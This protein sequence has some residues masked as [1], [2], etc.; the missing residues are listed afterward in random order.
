MPASTQRPTAPDSTPAQ[1][2][3]LKRPREIFRFLGTAAKPTV[4]L[5]CTEAKSLGH[6]WHAH[7]D[8][9]VVIQCT[10]FAMVNASAVEDN[11]VAMIHLII[12]VSAFARSA[13]RSPTAAARSALMTPTAAAR[14][15]FARPTEVDKSAFK[16]ATDFLTSATSAFVA[17]WGITARIA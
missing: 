10:N 17:R 9:E 11:T 14:S 5:R 12:T 8:C 1:L 13:F 3:T 16:S 7:E 6:G 4:R 2:S 15:A